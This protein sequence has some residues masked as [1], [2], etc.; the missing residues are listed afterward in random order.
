MAL[1]VIGGGIDPNDINKWEYVAGHYRHN[2]SIEIR[3]QA[4][5]R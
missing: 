5:T 1:Y 2:A 4:T 3:R